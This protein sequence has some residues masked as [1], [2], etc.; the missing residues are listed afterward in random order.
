M[1]AAPQALEDADAAIKLRPEWEKGYFRKAAALE[2][3]DKLQEVGPAEGGAERGGR[4]MSVRA[5]GRL[6]AASCRC[7]TREMDWSG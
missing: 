7:A 4:G 6:A 1:C 2:V 5:A 3:L